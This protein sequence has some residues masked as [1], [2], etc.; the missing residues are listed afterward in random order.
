MGITGLILGA[1]AAAALGGGT[2]LT[3]LSYSYLQDG[4]RVVLQET[5]AWS[6]SFDPMPDAETLASVVG[7]SHPP[8]FGIPFVAGAF[9]LLLFTAVRAWARDGRARRA[10]GIGVAATGGGIVA[11]AGMLALSVSG[12]MSNAK[13]QTLSGGSSWEQAYATGAGLWV[14]L[15][16]S[17]V[18]AVAAILAVCS[19]RR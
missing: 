12:T 18:A 5:T 15:A 9:L 7:D 6:T 19:T 17:V 4:D 10:A 11:S 8:Y 16:G 2:F 14:L 1:I 13:V 3:Y